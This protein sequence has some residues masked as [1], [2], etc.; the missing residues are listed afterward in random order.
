MNELIKF[1]HAGFLFSTHLQ[2]KIPVFELI[3]RF[4][5][6]RIRT[7]D[8]QLILEYLQ[9]IHKANGNV[10]RSSAYIFLVVLVIKLSLS[11]TD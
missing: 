8:I 7:I 11:Q 1:T 9:L 5:F 2:L 10:V 4:V 6:H 3:N